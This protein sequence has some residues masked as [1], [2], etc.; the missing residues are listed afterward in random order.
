MCFS[1]R[2]LSRRYCCRDE[3]V[4]TRGH[5]KPSWI[6]GP[7]RRDN[8]N[9]TSRKRHRCKATDSSTERRYIQSLACRIL[10][11]SQTHGRKHKS[12]ES[13]QSYVESLAQLD[14]S[15]VR[16]TLVCVSSAPLVGLRS[17]GAQFQVFYDAKSTFIPPPPPNP[18]TIT[19][20]EE[21]ARPLD[22]SR[23][24]PS[25]P[26]LQQKIFFFWGGGVAPPA[27]SVS[28]AVAPAETGLGN[29]CTALKVRSSY[30]T[31]RDNSSAFER[32]PPHPPPPHLR[33]KL[34][35]NAGRIEPSGKE[36]NE[37]SREFLMNFSCFENVP[38]TP[39]PAPTAT[40]LKIPY[41]CTQVACWL[42]CS[43]D[44]TFTAENFFR[45]G[46]RRGR[47]FFQGGM[48]TSHSF[49]PPTLALPGGSA[50]IQ[51]ADF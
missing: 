46:G 25:C 20:V 36:A 50:G 17:C 11:I 4:F 27:G 8:N 31:V 47:C 30:S 44:I 34:L 33:L 29:I 45:Q 18:G 15:S 28:A 39:P 51:T 12:R 49:F 43:R 9:L 48:S 21:K 42:H 38:V 10:I 16:D 24:A 26:A 41:S 40:F 6:Y 23:C 5:K 37:P 35:E 3:A 7:A 22:N 19:V 1:R 32:N 2:F 14:T 13:R